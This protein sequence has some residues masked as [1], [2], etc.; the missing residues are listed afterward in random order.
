M[1]KNIE[2]WANM[3][4]IG[5]HIFYHTQGEAERDKKDDDIF[6]GV[7]LSGEYEIEE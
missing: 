3:R 2:V 1:K 7:K 4:G 6:S 5:D